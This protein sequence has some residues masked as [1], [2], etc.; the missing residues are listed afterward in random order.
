M[1]DKNQNPQTEYEKHWHL[2]RRVPISLLLAII[3]QT[4]GFTWYVAGI[5]YQV[6]ANKE[7]LVRAESE[8]QKVSTVRDEMIKQGAILQ[9]LLTQ[10]TELRKDIKDIIIS[11][12]RNR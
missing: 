12:D 5:D 2:D 7:A 3:L 9:G 8:I 6:K 11:R 10:V 4:I 1:T